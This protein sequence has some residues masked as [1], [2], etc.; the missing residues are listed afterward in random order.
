MGRIENDEQRKIRNAHFIRAFEYVASVLELGQG[1]LAERI[2]S[3]S[4]HI[5]NFK[6][7]LR[8]VPPETITGLINIS[9]SKPGLQIFSEY[10]YGNSDIMLLANVSDEEMAA[11]KSRSGNP[12]YEAIHKRDKETERIL[13]VKNRSDDIQMTVLG[14]LVK[15]PEIIEG[16]AADDDPRPH[17]PTWADALLGILSKQ[18][19]ENEVLHS[20]LKQSIL[21]VRDMKQQ[22]TK[23]LSNL[24]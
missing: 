13:Q 4:S 3:K 22:L 16:M 11:A 17:L 9:A 8:P 23:L 15:E 7:G 2:G 14:H 24:K 19:A 1:E 21:E 10:L 12:D 5:S 18:I 6:K 20:E